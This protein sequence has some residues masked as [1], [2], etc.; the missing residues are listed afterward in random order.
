MMYCW[1]ALIAIAI[2]SAAAVFIFTNSLHFGWFLGV[3][4]LMIVMTSYKDD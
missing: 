3:A 4:V 1:I 2:M